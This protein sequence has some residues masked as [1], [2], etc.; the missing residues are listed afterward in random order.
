MGLWP[1]SK[2][3]VSHNEYGEKCKLRFLTEGGEIG[4]V[5]VDVLDGEREDFDAHS[6]DV[7]SGDFAHQRGELI[8]VFV[9][10]LD[11]QCAFEG[12]IFIIISFLQQSKR[13]NVR[14]LHASVVIKGRKS[15]PSPLFA[16]QNES[17]QHDA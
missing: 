6:A 4:D 14:S 3:V 15:R 9:D 5:V 1:S 11:G 12:E 10:L 7:R 8:P 2:S 16:A 17:D 13:F